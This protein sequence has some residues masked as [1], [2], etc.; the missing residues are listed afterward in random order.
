MVCKYLKPITQHAF[1]LRILKRL[2]TFTQQRLSLPLLQAG[3]DNL[4]KLTL[5]LI[6]LERR[7]CGLNQR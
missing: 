4:P 5:Y 6:L 1:P 3:D 2:V 7:E